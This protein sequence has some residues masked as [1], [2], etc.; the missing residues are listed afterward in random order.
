MEGAY[1]RGGAF[2]PSGVIYA[3]LLYPAGTGI[4]V[5]LPRSLDAPRRCGVWK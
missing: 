3:T 5:K 2:A 4:G 1:C